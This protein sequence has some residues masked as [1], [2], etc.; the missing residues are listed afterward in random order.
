MRSLQG[1]PLD[2]SRLLTRGFSRFRP[3][4]TIVLLEQS[5][6][7]FLIMSATRVTILH[8]RDFQTVL[9]D[10]HVIH[11]VALCIRRILCS[12][13]VTRVGSDERLT[14]CSSLG[15]GMYPSR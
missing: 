5:E 7:V 4:H 1:D 12:P 10:G 14:R 6:D 11:A 2:Q 3:F 9:L 15:V 13:Y 8:G